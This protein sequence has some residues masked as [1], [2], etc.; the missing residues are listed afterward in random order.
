M[1]D[2]FAVTIQE[3][4]HGLPVLRYRFDRAAYTALQRRRLGPALVH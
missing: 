3:A 2:L 1:T 4:K